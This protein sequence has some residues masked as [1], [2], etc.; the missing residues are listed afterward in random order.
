MAKGAQLRCYYDVISRVMPDATLDPL[1]DAA[2][3]ALL[4]WDAEKLR[5][6]MAK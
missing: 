1:D 2:V 4:N 5:Q 6:Q 3:Y